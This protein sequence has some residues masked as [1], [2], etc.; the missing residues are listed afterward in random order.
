[1]E[2]IVEFKNIWRSSHLK[3]LYRIG[4]ARRNHITIEHC[5]LCGQRQEISAAKCE[6]VLV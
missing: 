1:M 2:G 3:T 4:A 5:L 6:E